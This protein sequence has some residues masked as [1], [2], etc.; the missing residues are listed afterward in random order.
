MRTIRPYIYK[1]KGDKG[2]MP[3]K[4]FYPVLSFQISLIVLTLLVIWLIK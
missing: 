1:A 4:T 3:D 2:E